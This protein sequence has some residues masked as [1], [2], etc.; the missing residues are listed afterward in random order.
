MTPELDQHIREKYP[1]IFQHPCEMSVGDGWFDII[2]LLC[3]NI[4]NHIDRTRRDRHDQL[5]YNRALSRAIRND[6]T[7]Y[8]RLNKW[9][10]QKIDEELGYPEPQLN[11]VPEAC[12]QVVVSQIKEKFGTL[13]FYY[14]GGD[15][16]VNGLEHMADSMS[17]V[18][19]EACGCPGKRRS[20]APKRWIR[21]LCDK[22]A[23]EQ[24]YIED[25]DS[26][27]Q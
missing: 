21:T 15:E 4:Q 6:F 25:E 18:I 16:Y 22:H 2:D 20:S 3:A 7:T 27:S 26:T 19:C 9:L 10:Q 13:R 14:T 12:P 8:G 5:V 24:G 17:A 1:M 11:I 23:H